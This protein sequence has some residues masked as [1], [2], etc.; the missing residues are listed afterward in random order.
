MLPPGLF[1]PG[2]QR[3]GAP[4]DDSPVAAEV[5]GLNTVLESLAQ[6]RDQG[7]AGLD[8]A[9]CDHACTH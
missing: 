9:C 1:D 8:L 2:P 3:G 4:G 5:A 6:Q 7:G